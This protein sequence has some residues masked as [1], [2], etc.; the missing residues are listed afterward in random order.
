MTERKEKLMEYRKLPRG[1]ELLSIIGMG[2]SVIGEADEEEIIRTVQSAM[3]AGINI[4]DLA[5]GYGNTFAAYGKAFAGKREQVYLQIHFGTDYQNGEYGWTLDLDTI[6]AGV[7]RR[8]QELQTDYIDFGFIHCMDEISDFEAYQRN[9]V[10]AYMLELKEQGVIRHIGLS[11]HTPSVANAIL[12]LGIVDLMMFSINPAYDYQ[13]GDYGIGSGDE[14]QA[15]YRRCEKE[16]IGITVMKAFCGGQLLDVNQSPF[17]K[18]LSKYQ[19]IQYALDKPGVVSVLLGYANEK[20]LKEVLQFFSAS[21]EEKDYSVISS[22]TPDD[23]KGKCVYCKH[24]HP[25][26]EGLDIALI[27]KYYDLALLGDE[28]AKEHYLTLHKKADDCIA[29]GHCNSRCP[30]HVDQAKR[31]K[32]IAEYFK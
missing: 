18:E 30:F 9:G 6:K 14:R 32:E 28:L 8:L 16:G 29:C 27:N 21:A 15:L 19:C 25:C 12:D 11:S 2:S 10:L 13:H 3:D 20:E 5:A 24:C 31:M 4:F 22:F 1:K 7:A 26:P 23:A 17:H